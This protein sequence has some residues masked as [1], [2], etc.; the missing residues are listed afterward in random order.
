MK[1]M[2]AERKKRVQFRQEGA[3]LQLVFTIDAQGSAADRMD[4]ARKF[5]EEVS[6]WTTEE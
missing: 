2:A 5:L 3:L 6:G 1:R 4:E